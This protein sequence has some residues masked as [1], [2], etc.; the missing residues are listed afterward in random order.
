MAMLDVTEDVVFDLTGRGTTSPSGSTT[1]LA[2][3]CRIGGLPFLYAT[4][5]QFAMRRET[6]DFRR[7]RIDNE[8]NPGE[9]SLDSG[10]WIRS[11]S[12]WHYGAGL[13]TAEPL[14]VNDTEAG[15]RF[16]ASGGVDVW[17]P[18]QASLLRATTEKINES[19]SGQLLI[20]VETGVL[21][22]QGV[23]MSY[24]PNAGSSSAVTWGG[25]HAIESLTS[26]GSSYFVS[27]ETGIWKGTLPSG[28]GTRIYSAADGGVIRWVK[29]RL[30]AAI[31][32]SVYEITDIS[33]SSPPASLPAALFTHPNSSWVWTDFAEGPTVI[34]ASGYA[35]DTSS[36]YSIGV[37]SS[38]SAV[39]LNQPVVV[40][41]LP[42]G[43]VVK[44]VYTYVGA[45]VVVGTS[46]GVR[47]AAIGSDGSLSLG[48]LIVEIDGGSNDAV[49]IDRYVY[50]TGAADVDAGDRNKRAGLYRI[51]LG[52]PL[53]SADL[54]YAFASDITVPSGVNGAATQVTVAGDNLYFAV[55]GA[56]LYKQATT[57]VAEGWLETGRIR[58]GTLENKAWHDVRLMM[59]AG[60]TGSVTAHASISDYSKPSDARA[61]LTVNGTYNDQYGSFISV[62]S[63]PQPDM[64]VAFRLQ[65]NDAGTAP[66]TFKGFQVRAMPAPKRSRLIQIPL[67]LFNFEIDKKGVRHGQE[68]GAY[69]RLLALE[70]LEDT[71]ATVVYQDFT[72]GEYAQAYIEKVSFVR[73]TP[74]TRSSNNAGG[75]A[76]VLLRLV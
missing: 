60:A 11:Q 22:A 43:E 50:A 7:Q 47:I 63:A 46:K 51:D 33:P 40:A 74:P 66:A 75:V 48:P 31:G 41:E 73:T 64:Y 42:R 58:L 17:T 39:A 29:Q 12:S 72:T 69:A 70:S 53:A 26:N 23:D 5:D 8:R 21:F 54:R 18:G 14:E 2:W 61:I 65:S 36:I 62:T 57:Y 19:G 56:G 32:G 16:A 35:G 25:S 24:Q 9:Q 49:A 76:Q 6:A 20:G 27:D 37:T 28:A 3:D 44:S 30:M 34:Y 4:S 59:E 55:D 38:T 15:F 52:Q 67:M 13:T 1:Y 71:A 10:Y 45:Y 68:G